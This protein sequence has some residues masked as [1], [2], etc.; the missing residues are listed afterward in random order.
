MINRFKMLGALLVIFSLMTYTQAGKLGLSLE[1]ESESILL[2][3]NL[4][5]YH[6]ESF[7]NNFEETK[8]VTLKLKS[9]AGD[10]ATI[11]LLTI[12]DEDGNKVLER[13]VENTHCSTFTFQMPV[14]SN[15]LG[16]Q[17][18]DHI[19]EV[20]LDG[21]TILKDLTPYRF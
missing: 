11:K 6:T 2:A 17:Y 16:L 3:S 15:L 12:R 4:T 13:F 9:Y 19:E 1:T 8:T 7:D 18:G 21:N 5:P 10:V 14:D 20:K